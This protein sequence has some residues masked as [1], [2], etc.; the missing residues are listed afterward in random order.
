VPT[1]AFVFVSLF[2]SRLVDFTIVVRDAPAPA[3]PR[4]IREH[5]DGMAQPMAS[6]RLACS[7]VSKKAREIAPRSAAVAAPPSPA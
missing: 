1:S 3:A 6:M 2:V 5:D 7:R 4:D